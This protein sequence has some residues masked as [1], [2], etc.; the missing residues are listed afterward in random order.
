[1]TDT[2][3]NLPIKLHRKKALH[4]VN[5][6]LVDD[7]RAVAEAIRLMAI[8]SGAR[9]RRADCIDSAKR[10]LTLFRP[11]IIIVD[12]ALPDGSGE[13]LVLSLDELCEADPA[14]LIIS[15]ADEDE[16]SAVAT[17]TAAD[18]FLA[19]P[20]I[21]LAAFQ[22]AIIS[23]VSGRSSPA[24]V[25]V[26]DFEPDVSTSGALRH[27]FENMFDLLSEALETN[28]RADIEFAAKFLRGVVRTAPDRD[29]A[30]AIRA[31]E[32]ALKKGEFGEKESKAVIALLDGRIQSAWSEAS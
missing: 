12:L 19:K 26:E 14:V 29:L 15:G 16:I 5:I 10:H 6:L 2:A 18:G 1:M 7:S 27:D 32:G 17:R 4:G 21:D 23:A 11:D 28:N 20:I 31:L 30:S 13:E 3:S 25:V 9:L 8:K 22:Q 24:L